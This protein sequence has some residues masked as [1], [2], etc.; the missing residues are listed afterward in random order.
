MRSMST[1]LALACIGPGCLA[2]GESLDAETSQAVDTT[3]G[4]EA[5]PEVGSEVEIDGTF[6]PHETLADGTLPPDAV[7]DVV[8]GTP[9]AV[10]C[11]AGPLGATGIAML[12]QRTVNMTPVVFDGGR[13]YGTRARNPSDPN[14]YVSDLVA[15]DL[16]RG[17]EQVVTPMDDLLMPLDARDGALLYATFGEGLAR[18]G[19][20]YLGPDGGAPMTLFD[21]PF[22]VDGQRVYPALFPQPFGWERPVRHVERGMA[23]WREYNEVMPYAMVSVHAMQDGVVAKVWESDGFVGADVVLRN[24]RAAWLHQHLGPTKLWL[25]ELHHGLGE[26]ARWVAEGVLDFALTDDALWWIDGEYTGGPVTRLDLTTGTISEAHPGPCRYLVAGAHEVLSMCGTGIA[27][28]SISLAG[29]RPTALDGVA[30]RVFPIG[31]ELTTDGP[32]PDHVAV[33]LLAI[34]GDRA[35]WAEYPR[36]VMTTLDPP[37]S[38]VLCH[39]GEGSSW[40]QLGSVASGTIATVG[41]LTQGCWCCHN[42]GHWDSP[43]VQLRADGMAW[44]YPFTTPADARDNLATPIGWLLFDQPCA[45]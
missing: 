33:S 45:P 17:T 3:I 8:Y 39:P 26:P 22:L 34:E 30:V 18:A 15:I 36:A 27:H 42:D 35:V 19:L 12:D 41:E 11:H 16:A 37:G 32:A 6:A 14:A 24:R 20:H 40:L 4:V 43:D 1:W 5:S 31:G 7:S 10:A 2:E 38:G 28:D 25:A 44:N 23:V 21:H 9:G 13:L 29:A